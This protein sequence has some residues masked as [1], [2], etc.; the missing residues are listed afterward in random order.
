[1]EALDD[2]FAGLTVEIASGLFGKGEEV[3]VFT[4]GEIS[5]LFVRVSSLQQRCGCLVLFF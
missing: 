2:V 5:V 1:V 3:G 4:N